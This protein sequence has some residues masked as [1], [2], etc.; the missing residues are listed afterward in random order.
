MKRRIVIIG[1]ARQGS[2][3]ARYWCAQ[4]AQVTITDLRPKAALQGEIAALRGLPVDY[5]LGGHPLSLLDACDL[6][7]LSGGVPPETPLPQEARKRGIPLCNDSLLTLRLAPTPMIG[8]T[9][10][11]GKTTTT[12]LVGE[13]LRASGFKTWVGGNIGVP[14]I[15]KLGDIGREDKMALELSSFQLQLFQEPPPASPHIAA[16]LNIT[17][18]HLDRHPSM[19]HYTAAK[20]NILRFQSENDVAVLGLDNP[21]TGRWQQSGRV[22]IEQGAGQDAVHFPIQARQVSFSLAQAAPEGAY[23]DR[24][25][26]LWRWEGRERAICDTAEIQLRGRHNVANILAACAVG[27]AAGA[28]PEAMRHVAVTFTGVPHRL[29]LVQVIEGVSWYNDSIATAPERVIA[30]LK[31]F[32]EPIILLAGGRDK[33]LPW[34]DMAHLALRRVRHLVLFGEA[35]DLIAQAIAD[36]RDHAPDSGRLRLHFGNNLE[37]AVARAAQLAQAGDVVL[38]SPGGTSFDA[39]RDFQA[40]GEH[41]RTLVHLLHKEKSQ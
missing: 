25:R 20:A 26:L 29:E 16:V 28:T 11:S 15:D 37:Q 3:L 1:L 13:M 40:R 39:Y 2:A 10:A 27:G 4:G 32:D 31:A 6:L 30:A 18:N 22:D 19:A 17:P 8:I 23:L 5:V 12:A 36:A 21:I 7:F 35:A 14:L 41:F 9:G 38:L 33:H 34:A 24:T